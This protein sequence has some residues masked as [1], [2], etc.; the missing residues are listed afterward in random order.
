MAASAAS[1]VDVMA[2]P[3]L[4][5]G[6]AGFAGSH[7]LDQLAGDRVDT[8]AWHRPGGHGP[9]HVDGVTW[10]GVNLL[11]QASVRAELER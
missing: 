1:R 2:G 3:T 6:A 10:R 4:V 9:R 7:L 8:V 11:D 5:T